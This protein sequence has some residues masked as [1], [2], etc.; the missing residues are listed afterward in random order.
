MIYNSGCLLKVQ[1]LPCLFTP[2]TGGSGAYLIPLILFNRVISYI[3][4]RRHGS[5]GLNIS[6]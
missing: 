2:D 1:T 3:P 5:L 6:H 4:N